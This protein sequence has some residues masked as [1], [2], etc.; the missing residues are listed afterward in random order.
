MSATSTSLE[1]LPIVS[2]FLRRKPVEFPISTSNAETLSAVG[3]TQVGHLVAGRY[4]ELIGSPSLLGAGLPTVRD[5]LQLQAQNLAELP[6]DHVTDCMDVFELITGQRGISS[7][8]AQR[9]AIM[10]LREDKVTGRTR[11]TIHVTTKAMLADGLTKQGV[12]LQLMAFATTGRWV[13]PEDTVVRARRRAGD[14]PFN[15]KALQDLSW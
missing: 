1:A 11:F 6:V 8:R 4:T 5:L 12:F 2:S 13:I 10:A 14:E 7:D 15:E 9:L 3:C